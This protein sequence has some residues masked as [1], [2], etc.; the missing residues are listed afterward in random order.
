M[1]SPDVVQGF[2]GDNPQWAYSA[3]RPQGTSRA[4]SNYWD[5]NYSNI[6]GQYTGY[7]GGLMQQGQS[8][9]TSFMDYLKG[10]DWEKDYQSQGPRARGFYPQYASPQMRWNV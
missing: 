8:P 7:L 4:Q 9:T 5:R 3:Q 2:F 10:F 6:Y 1:V